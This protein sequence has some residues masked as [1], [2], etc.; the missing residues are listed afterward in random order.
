MDYFRGKAKGPRFMMIYAVPGLQ[1]VLAGKRHHPDEDAWH[2]GSKQDE[3][4]KCSKA[5]EE[6]LDGHTPDGD[7]DVE[8]LGN[9]LIARNFCYKVAVSFRS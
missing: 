7:K 3:P 8:K 1:E 5:L 4:R 6:I 2:C 9:E